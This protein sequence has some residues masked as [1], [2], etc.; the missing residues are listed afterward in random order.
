MRRDHKGQEIESW[1][2]WW[3]QTTPESEIRKWD[4]YGL[5]P[6]ILKYTPRFG[7]VVEAGCGMGRWVFYLSRLGV[8]IE[9]LDFIGPTIAKL[10]KWKSDKDFNVNFVQ[11][12]VTD[13]PYEENSLSGYLSFGVVEH[14]IDGPLLPLK[15]A[16]KALRPG[17]IAIVTTPSRSWVVVLQKTKSTIKRIIKRSIGRKASKAEFF[18]YEYTPKQLAKYVREA[19]LYTTQISGA[20]LF[21]TFNQFGKFKGRNLRKGSFAYWFSN[22]FE[23]SPLKRFGAQSVTISV[24]LAPKMHCF[25]SGDLSA[26]PDSLERFSVPICDEMQDSPLAQFYLKKKK[27]HY[28]YP[29]E[30]EPQLKKPTI[31]Q[32]QKSGKRYMTDPLFEDYGFAY[33]IHPSLLKKPETNIWLSNKSLTPI[34]RKRVL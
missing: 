12:D 19:G 3:D 25:L 16:Y 23:K 17:G 26:T 20:D 33:K 21:F 30:I 34:W 11:G 27:P 28:H 15:Q 14:F 22:S 29:Y 6:W 18:Q 8:E 4:F 1:E 2:E 5:R 7:K 24:K 10:N 9:G 31:E 32:C 13:L